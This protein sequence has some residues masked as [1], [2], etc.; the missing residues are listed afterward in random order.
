MHIHIFVIA[1]LRFSRSFFFFFFFFLWSGKYAFGPFKTYERFLRFLL[2][3]YKDE[4]QNLFRSSGDISIH[5]RCMNS[6][7]EVYKYNNRLF[8]ETMN[9]V[10]STGA[11]ICNIWQFNVLKTHVPTSNRYGLNSIPYKINQLWNLF[12]KT[13][14]H[15]RH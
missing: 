11:N 9:E 14:N 8:P 4:F 3:S 15:L 5:Q 6:L 1:L 7:T 12:L 13:S 2:K 10:F